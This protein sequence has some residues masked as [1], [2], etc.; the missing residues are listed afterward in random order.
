M[1]SLCARCSMLAIAIVLLVGGCAELVQVGDSQ[2]DKRSWHSKAGW[3]AENYFSDPQVIALCEAIEA[4]DLEEIDRLVA[5]G[6]DVNAKGKGNMTPLLWAFPDNKLERFKRLL[7]HGAD[8]NVITKSDFGNPKAFQPG[9]SVTHMAAKTRFS[10]YLQCVMEHGGDPNLVEP[11]WGST[12]IFTVIT[13]GVPDRKERVQLLIDKG[14]DVD[15]VNSV[16]ATPA[17]EAVGWFGQYDVALMLLKAGADAGIYVENQNSKLIHAVVGDERRLPYASPQQRAEYQELLQ[18]LVDHGESAEEARK[19][20]DRWRER[21]GK[22]PPKRLGQ[23]LK[24]EIAERVAR[25]QAEADEEAAEKQGE[26]K[27]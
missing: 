23:L 3:T 4:D 7:E 11:R 17:I 6:A 10:G 26:E 14:A 8:P 1:T 27:Q 20:L 15:H 18:W 12:P 9:D 16:G 21:A 25:E 22:L 13:A 19:D 24:K 2:P 5:A